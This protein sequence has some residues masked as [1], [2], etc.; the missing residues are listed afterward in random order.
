MIGVVLEHLKSRTS[1]EKIYFVLF[2]DAARAAFEEAYNKL[3]S[4]PPAHVA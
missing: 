3:A 2:D 4:H 1:L